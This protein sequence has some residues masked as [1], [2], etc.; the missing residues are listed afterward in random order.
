MAVTG[1]EPEPGDLPVL[2]LAGAARAVEGRTSAGGRFVVGVVGPPG[3]GKSTVAD[4]LAD[5][6][7]APVVPMDGHHLPNAELDRLRLRHVKGS[8]ETFDAA[9]FVDLVRRLRDSPTAIA[10]PT[11]DRAADEPE[12]GGC[13]VAA[14]DRVVVVEGNYLLLPEPPWSELRSLLDFVVYVDVDDDVRV[15]RLVDR[16]VAHGRTRDEAI[17]FVERSDEINARRVASGRSRADAAIPNTTDRP[18]REP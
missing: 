14:D 17:G 15:R 2:D 13:S 4:D 6:L 18:V 3:S 9:G 8:P 12:P 10:A 1:I 5:R 7:A 11:F 16:H